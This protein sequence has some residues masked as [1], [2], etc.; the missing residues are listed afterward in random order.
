MN[1]L[2][3]GR[4][5]VA[6]QQMSRV[7]RELRLKA[8]ARGVDYEAHQTF[9]SLCEAMAGLDSPQEAVQSA[10]RIALAV[11]VRGKGRRA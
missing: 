10:Q 2:E 9:R 1:A 3:R 11:V 4:K 5:M 6:E 7:E 8:A